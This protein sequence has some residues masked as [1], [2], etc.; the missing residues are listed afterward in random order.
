MLIFRFIF[1][2][3]N[4]FQVSFKDKIWDQES[5]FVYK[6]VYVYLQ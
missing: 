4:P 1:L 2:H 5:V 3:F 6:Y